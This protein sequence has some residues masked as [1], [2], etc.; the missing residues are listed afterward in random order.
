MCVCM[1]VCMCVSVHTIYDWLNKFYALGKTG[2]GA[3][4]GMG[5]EWVKPGDETGRS[6]GFLLE[7]PGTD[8]FQVSLHSF[9]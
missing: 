4:V 3:E 6:H 9:I 2:S 1:C 8:L 7:M 5:D